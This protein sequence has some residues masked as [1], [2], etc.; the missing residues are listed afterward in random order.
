VQ[1]YAFAV[2]F[3][4]DFLLR[5]LVRGSPSFFGF[6]SA[7]SAFFRGCCMNSIYI[8]RLLPACCVWNLQAEKEGLPRTTRSE[9]FRIK[10]DELGFVSAY[11]L[12]RFWG[13]GFILNIRPYFH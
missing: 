3:S 5:G 4:G 2:K 6:G 9:N 8:W 13:A 7:I 1:L 10:M 12:H 11:V